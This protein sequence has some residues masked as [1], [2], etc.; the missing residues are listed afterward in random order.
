LL[1]ILPSLLLGNICLET[2]ALKDGLP[3]LSASVNLTAG[4]ARLARHGDRVALC[5]C[6]ELKLVLTDFEP[7]PL[8]L[9]LVFLQNRLL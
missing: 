9:G 8:P 6:G 1:H 5:R 7:E 2:T 3:V 4:S